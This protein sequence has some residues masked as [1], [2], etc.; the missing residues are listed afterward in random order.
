MRKVRELHNRLFNWFTNHHLA[1]AQNLCE[2]NL[3]KDKLY[4]TIS[5]TTNANNENTNNHS[6]NNANNLESCVFYKL[7]KI[8]FFN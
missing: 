8:N 4:Q 6:E 2:S 3:K 7:K 5:K 1:Q